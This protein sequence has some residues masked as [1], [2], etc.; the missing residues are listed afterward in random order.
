MNERFEISESGF[1]PLRHALFIRSP[2][3]LFS[4]MFFFVFLDD[5]VKNADDIAHLFR[6]DLH[7]S[8]SFVVWRSEKYIKFVFTCKHYAK[9]SNR[10]SRRKN[11][12]R[13]QRPRNL[14]KKSHT[15]RQWC[16]NRRTEKRHRPSSLHHHPQRLTISVPHP[17]TFH[18]DSFAM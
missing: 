8:T 7:S 10:D 2:V 17:P 13:R 11:Q 14:R 5:V 12:H 6:V 16:Q 1:Q 15:I 18:A 4:R 9:K 3:S